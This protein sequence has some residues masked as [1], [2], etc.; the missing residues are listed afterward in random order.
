MHEAIPLLQDAL[1]PLA[2]FWDD[3]LVEDVLVN[4]PGEVFV[5]RAGRFSRHEVP[6]DVVDL[7]GIAILAGSLKQQNVGRSTPLLSA[8]FPLG[9][10]QH[11][12]Q[13]CLPPAVNADTVALAIRRPKGVAPTLDEVAGVFS[14]TTPR[15][16]GLS[17]EDAALLGL[18]RSAESSAPHDRN[19]AY[20]AFLR[21]AMAAGKTVVLCGQVGSGKTHL[22]M[23]LAQEIP[24]GDRLVTIQDADEFAALPHRN[25]VD[26]FYSKGGQGE[27]A[28]TPD[29]LVEASL[30]LSMRWLLLQEVRGREAFSFMRARRS[31]HPGLTTCHAESAAEAIPALALMAKQHERLSGVDLPEIERMMRGLIDVVVHLHRPGGAFAVSEVWFRAAEDAGL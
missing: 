7:E 12:I 10:I 25:R 20:S 5:R 17:P 4:R 13:A 24:L 15:H 11:R 29:D 31:G 21:A 3:P 1:T 14:D 6:L 23:A 27:A 16:I 26:L 19:G 30:R 9:G 18:Y 22:A 2:T 8:D 28:L